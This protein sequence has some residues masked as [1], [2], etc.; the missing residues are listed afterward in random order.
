MHAPVFVC[1]HSS[2]NDTVISAQPKEESED[3]RRSQFGKVY[4]QHAVTG[5]DIHFFFL[6]SLLYLSMDQ[7]C[8]IATRELDELR[9]EIQ[10]EQEEGQISEDNLRVSC[11]GHST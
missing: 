7:K 8:N 4:T 11:W 6:C 2:T 5:Y 3:K 9:E 1:V 10:R